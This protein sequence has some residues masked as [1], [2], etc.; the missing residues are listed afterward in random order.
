[1]DAQLDYNK[2]TNATK[3]QIITKL[4]KINSNEAK[5]EMRNVNK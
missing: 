2:S 3:H 5:H 1:M 4:N